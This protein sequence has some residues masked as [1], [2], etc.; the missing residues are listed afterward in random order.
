MHLRLPGY[1]DEGPTLEV[2]QYNRQMDPSK[3]AANRPGFAHIAFAVDDVMAARDAVLC[4]EGAEDARWMD[5]PVALE[6]LTRALLSGIPAPGQPPVKDPPNRSCA[7]WIFRKSMG[8]V[9]ASNRWMVGAN[10]GV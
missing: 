5:L 6:L 4:F 10:P 3:P 7:S 2:F 8:S 1:G 9:W